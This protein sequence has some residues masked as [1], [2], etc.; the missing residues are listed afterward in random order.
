MSEA[1][2]VL[3][4]DDDR[5]IRELLKIFLSENGYRVSTA[6]TAAEARDRMHGLAFDLV[7]LDIMMPGE[8]GLSLASGLRK[9]GDVTP[10][11]MLSAL[12]DTADRIKGLATGSD[13]YLGKPFDPAELLLRIQNLLRRSARTPPAPEEVSFGAF[14]F[15]IKRGELRDAAGVVRLT[16]GERD[17]LRLLAERAGTP[18]SRDELGPAESTRG[19]DVQVNRL[20]QKI[21]TDPS[22]PVFLQTVRSAGYVLHVEG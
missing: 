16:S 1:A 22:N 19:V 15:H 3:V 14:R 20:R 13:D 17:M 9:N 18:V 10:L 11:L 21:E 6:G 8:D 5:R 12:S 7:V 4:V 2:H